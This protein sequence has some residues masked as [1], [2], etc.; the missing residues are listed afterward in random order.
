MSKTS[1]KLDFCFL[2]PFSKGTKTESGICNGKF[3]GWTDV[4]AEEASSSFS[5]NDF[6][7]VVKLWKKDG[8]NSI[9]DALSYISEMDLY[10]HPKDEKMLSRKNVVEKMTTFI[11]TSKE[12]DVLY[13][14]KSDGTGGNE[15]LYLAH[16]PKNWE[17]CN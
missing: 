12:G 9:G 16:T 2:F 3:R 8:L 13:I 11:E 5:K 7:R 1:N 4:F 6:N 10:E 14:G 17:G 15:R